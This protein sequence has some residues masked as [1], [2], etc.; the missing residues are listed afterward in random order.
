MLLRVLKFLKKR[1]ENYISNWKE[2][3]NI[4]KYGGIVFALTCIGGMMFTPE[5]QRKHVAQ[6]LNILG[7]FYM[8]LMYKRIK[9]TQR[10]LIDK[11][12]EIE[13][14]KRFIEVH[15]KETI[16][17]ITYAKRIQDA[18]LPPTD[19]IKANLPDSFVLYKPKDIVAGDFYWMEQINDTIL[20]AAADC[21]GHGVPGAM[22]SVVCSNALNR[23]VKEFHFSDTGAILD[24]VTDLVLETFEKSAAEVQDGMDISMLSINKVTRQIQWSGANNPLWY[25]EGTEKKEITADKQP[26]GKSSHRKPFTTHQIDYKENTTFYLFTDGYADQFGGAAGKKFKYK[27]FSDLLVK[28]NH[29]SQHVQKNIIET[30]FEDWKGNL[31]QVDDVCVIGIKI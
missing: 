26:V 10:E 21:T 30:A 4:E 13:L 6:Y 20:I 3:S 18:I 11:N 24:K 27:Q 15:Q 31:E 12:K 8:S 29:L 16:D 9:K 14:Q 1:K 2:E 17:S 22:V 7:I 28:Y 25:F 23:A 19:L 5:A